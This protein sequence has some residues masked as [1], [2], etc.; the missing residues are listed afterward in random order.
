[1]AVEQFIPGCFTKY[2]NNTG[3]STITTKSSN[4]SANIIGLKTECLVHFFYQKSGKQLMVVDVQGNGGYDLFDPEIASIEL[5][6]KDMNYLYC[7]GNLSEVDISAFVNQ[8]KC[9]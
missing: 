8:H 3:L 1:M 4:D 9:N 2:M 7:T 5:V 6:D